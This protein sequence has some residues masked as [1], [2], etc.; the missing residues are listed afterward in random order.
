MANS[1][2]IAVAVKKFMTDND[3]PFTNLI[4]IAADGVPNMMGRNKGKLL[5]NDQPEMMPVR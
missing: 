4:S 1:Y 5:K 2:K 3:I